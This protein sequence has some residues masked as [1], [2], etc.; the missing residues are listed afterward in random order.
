MFHIRYSEIKNSQ[1]EVIALFVVSDPNAGEAILHVSTKLLPVIEE[2]MESVNNRDGFPNRQV[3]F[4][5]QA[6]EVITY[7][8]VH[9]Y[10]FNCVV[11]DFP[12]IV[13][14][15]VRDYEKSLEATE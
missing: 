6:S 2:K 8:I 7:V 3:N 14:G 13:Q 15:W 12:K 11:N 5:S 4:G 10:N 9:Q 1:W